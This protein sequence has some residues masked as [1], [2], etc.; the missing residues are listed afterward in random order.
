LASAGPDS[1]VGRKGLQVFEITGEKAKALMKIFA[2]SCT[3]A[4]VT[5][6]GDCRH[7][8]ILYRYLE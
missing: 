5:G 3:F 2:I 6:Y 1:S 4:A 8:R 7:I